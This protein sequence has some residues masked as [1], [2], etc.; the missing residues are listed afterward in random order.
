MLDDGIKLAR[1]F[2]PYVPMNPEMKGDPLAADLMIE[3]LAGKI[4]T[5]H[6]PALGSQGVRADQILFQVDTRKSTNAKPAKA[7]GNRRRSK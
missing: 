1:V 6:E 5:R 2:T 4:Q 3:D 7:R